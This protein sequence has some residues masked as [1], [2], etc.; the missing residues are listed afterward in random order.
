[1]NLKVHFDSQSILWETGKVADMAY[2]LILLHIKKSQIEIRD[3]TFLE[4]NTLAK[5]SP[6]LIFNFLRTGLSLILES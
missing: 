1:M 3:L 5:S 2:M 4:I 6:M